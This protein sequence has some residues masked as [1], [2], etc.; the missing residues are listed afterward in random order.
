MHLPIWIRFLLFISTKQ[1]NH[2]SSTKLMKALVKRHIKKTSDKFDTLRTS[3]G[4]N[5]NGKTSFTSF[6]L[7]LYDHF[8]KLTSLTDKKL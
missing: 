3:D 7:I 1:S 4:V 5:F 8:K 2:Q 6:F